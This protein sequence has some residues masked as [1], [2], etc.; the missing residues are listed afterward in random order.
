LALLIDNSDGDAASTKSFLKQYKSVFE[1]E[2]EKK[3]FLGRIKPA[4]R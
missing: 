1:L 4:K 3:R 2:A